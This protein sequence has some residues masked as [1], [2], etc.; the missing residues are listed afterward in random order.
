[1]L[2]FLFSQVQYSQR[3]SKEVEQMNMKNVHSSHLKAI[4]Y[5]KQSQTLIVEFHGGRI[6]QYSNVPALEYQ[7][8][9]SAPSHGTYF[10]RNIR[11]HTERY[12][13]IELT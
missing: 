10:D 13:Y 5:D 1:M 9:M 2:H 12:P 4:G 7:A 3:L 6:Y 8:L 11:K